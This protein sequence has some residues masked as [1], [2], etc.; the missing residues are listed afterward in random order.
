MEEKITLCGDD[1]ALCPRYNAHSPAK[2]RAAAELWYRIGWRDSVVPDDEIACGGCSAQKSCTYG[3]V[4]CTGRHGVEKCSHCKE[5][6]CGTI[7][8]MLERSK[9]YQTRCKERCPP[10][11]YR[12]LQKAFFNKEQNLRK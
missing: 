5:F 7:A 1:C 2:L 11:E 12:T 6:P 9:A 8:E 3:L 10:E 4:E